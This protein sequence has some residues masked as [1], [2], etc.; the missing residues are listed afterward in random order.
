MAFSGRRN[1]PTL[2]YMKYQARRTL[3][4]GHGYDAITFAFSSSPGPPSHWRS[5]RDRCRLCSLSSQHGPD[6][7]SMTCERAPGLSAQ[8]DQALDLWA[9]WLCAVTATGA[10]QRRWIWLIPISA[11]EPAS[12]QMS[13]ALTLLR[14]QS[15][16]PLCGEATSMRNLPKGQSTRGRMR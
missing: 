5:M 8:G 2:P 1:I 12:W 11:G 15:R 4:A 14:E 13:G 6:Y 3:C 9:R 7:L 10:L 16:Y